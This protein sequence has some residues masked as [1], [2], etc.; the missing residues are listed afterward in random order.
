MVIEPTYSNIINITSYLFLALHVCISSTFLH[1]ENSSFGGRGSWW[2]KNRI[3]LWQGDD[4]KKKIVSTKWQMCNSIIDKLLVKA[5][6]SL[7]PEAMLL[8]FFFL[9]SPVCNHELNRH[10]A[11]TPKFRHVDFKTMQMKKKLIFTSEL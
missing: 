5:N 4:K 7:L 6:V 10:I 3:V 8:L 11:K 1:L 9:T 2:K